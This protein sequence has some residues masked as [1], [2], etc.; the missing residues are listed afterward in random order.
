MRDVAEKFNNFEE[1]DH[2]KAPKSSREPKLAPEKR[3]ENVRLQLFDLMISMLNCAISFR[4][5]RI[6]KTM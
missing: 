6:Y 3:P 4:R 2:Q 1:A 5:R